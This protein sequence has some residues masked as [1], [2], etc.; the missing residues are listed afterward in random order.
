MPERAANRCD[1]GQRRP[2]ESG[3]PGSD[4]VRQSGEEVPMDRWGFRNVEI[5]R[6]VVS[7]RS[8][9]SRKSTV[10][11]PL[12]TALASLGGVATI[13]GQ[14]TAATPDSGSPVTPETK[15]TPAGSPNLVFKAGEDLLGL[16]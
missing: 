5:R 12:A 8:R 3:E 4:W 6:G 11:L 16:L 14:A 2:P 15:A 9:M 7:G 10:I 1:G 13:A